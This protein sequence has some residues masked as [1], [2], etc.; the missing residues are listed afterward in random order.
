MWNQVLRAKGP[1]AVQ[2]TWVKGHT[3]EQFAKWGLTE[4]QRDGNHAADSAANQAVGRHPSQVRDTLKWMVAAHEAYLDLAKAIDELAVEMLMRRASRAKERKVQ[5][6]DEPTYRLHYRAGPH[7]APFVVI[8]RQ[9]W[10][11]HSDVSNA[12]APHES[13]MKAMPSFIF[14]RTWA[15]AEQGVGC[16]W[17]ELLLL[18]ETSTGL[19]VRVDGQ[20]MDQEVSVNA[21]VAT[22]RRAFK[23]ELAKGQCGQYLEWFA[24]VHAMAAPLIMMGIRTML[25]GVPA[26]PALTDREH[27]LLAH[28]IL[29][30]RGAHLRT[31]HDAFANGMLKLPRVHINGAMLPKWRDRHHPGHANSAVW[32]VKC[33]HCSLARGV[34]GKPMRLIRGWP[35]IRRN[36]CQRARCGMGVSGLHGVMR[37]M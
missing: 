24:P 25:G 30:L 5:V 27:D 16:T 31:Q 7:D 35:K 12:P 9:A 17:L 18:F 36:R 11:Y 21:I 22:F 34:R 14:G 23:Q 26:L 28:A 6:H 33:P 8:D 37:H 15:K 10:D 32:K 13:W 29:H 4:A 1:W 2:V 20:R 3:G 19:E